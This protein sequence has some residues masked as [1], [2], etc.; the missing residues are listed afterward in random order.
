LYHVEVGEEWT[1]HVPIAEFRVPFRHFWRSFSRVCLD[2]SHPKRLT[3]V[4]D[5]KPFGK[6]VAL[7]DCGDA[8]CHFG[9]AMP[10]RYIEYKLQV[11]GHRPEFRRDWFDV[12]WLQNAQRDVH[13]VMFP[14]HWHPVDF[15]KKKLPE[16][17][18][19]HPY[20][21]MDVIE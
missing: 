16:V 21:G 14:N 5:G 6:G 15:D 12:K 10:T 2:T 3:R 19:G 18:R 20:W 1:R 17:M 8:V 7:V 11:S 4:Q 13:P 9:Y